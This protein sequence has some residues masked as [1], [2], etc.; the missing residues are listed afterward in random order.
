[1]KP[2]RIFQVDAFTETAFSG[3]PAAVC[4]LEREADR[5]WMQNV[6]REMNLSETAFVV[7]REGGGFGLRWFT[8]SVEIPLCGHATLASAHVLWETGELALEELARFSTLSGELIA[9]RKGEWIELDFPTKPVHPVS[10]KP[11]LL[12]ALGVT[13]VFV[14]S[15]GANDLVQVGSEAEVVAAQP[16]LVRLKAASPYGTIVTAAASTNGYDFVSRYF[17]PSL[18]INEDPVTGSSHCALGAYWATLLKKNSF[19]A[20]QVSPRGGTLRVEVQGPRTILG[21]KAITVSR[22]E[23]LVPLVPSVL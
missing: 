9:G 5:A 17:A 1:M 21:G 11:E 6:A 7:R 4:L 13:A 8:P 19:T 18:G 15:D 20:R 23:L 14:G 2:P 22:G 16:D 3:N 10:P 12:E